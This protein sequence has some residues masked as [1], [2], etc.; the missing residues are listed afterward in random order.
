MV[1]IIQ[2]AITLGATIGGALFDMSGYQA[3]FGA[4]SVL[5]LLGASLTA[6]AARLGLQKTMPE[7][8]AQHA[9]IPAE[10]GNYACF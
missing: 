10:E 2:L 5:L 3:T 6:V 9:I 8:H 1:A 7:R 4:S